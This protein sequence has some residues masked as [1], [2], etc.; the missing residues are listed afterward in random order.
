MSNFTIS[1]NRK[2]CGTRSGYFG[3]EGV[4]KTPSKP[5]EGWRGCIRNIYEGVSKTPE[6]EGGCRTSHNGV[7]GTKVNLTQKTF[8]MCCMVKI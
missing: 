6:R 1:G 7:S 4:W 2:S 8:S 3:N 5:P